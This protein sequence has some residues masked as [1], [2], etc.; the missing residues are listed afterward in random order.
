MFAVEQGVP[1]PMVGRDYNAARKYPFADMAAGSSFFVP[2]RSPTA[3]A[4]L[5]RAAGTA[6]RRR[7]G[8]SIKFVVRV[9]GEG[10]RCWRKG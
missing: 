3:A 8:L 5:I 2:S 1:L 7:H 10:A 9:D 4:R 6:F